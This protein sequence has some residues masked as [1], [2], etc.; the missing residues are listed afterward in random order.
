MDLILD[1]VKKAIAA[2]LGLL[3]IVVDEEFTDNVE[4]AVK[5]VVDFGTEAAK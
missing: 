1:F 4:N 3:G 2:L 5:D